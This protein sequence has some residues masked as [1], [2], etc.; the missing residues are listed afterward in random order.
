MLLLLL[1]CSKGYDDAG[2]QLQAHSDALY[3]QAIASGLKGD[4][5]TAHVRTL[6]DYAKAMHLTD[7]LLV[8]KPRLR[9][10]NATHAHKDS[11]GYAQ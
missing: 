7:S 3:E 1:G 9:F 10:W 8:G 11:V 4:A 5:R 2:K 6:P